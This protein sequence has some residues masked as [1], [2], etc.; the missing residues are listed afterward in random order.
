MA[1]GFGATLGVGTTDRIDTAG[2]S[3]GSTY[4]WACSVNRN[5]NGGAGFGS[6]FQHGSVG[7]GNAIFTNG[8]LGTYE[9][10]VRF[11]V[12]SG[13]WRWTRPATGSFARIMAIVDATSTGNTPAVYMNGVLQ[14]LTLATAPVGV[15]APL[16]STIIRIGNN[17]A[18]TVNWDG[19]L[20]EF[21]AWPRRLTADDAKAY[22]IGRY[23]PLLIPGGFPL[24]YVPMLRENRDYFGTDPTITGT[25]VQPHDRVIYPAG[26]MAMG[27]D[28]AA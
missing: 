18:L 8:G 4:T 11:S 27:N 15:A 5:G 14:T 28:G 25:Q 9:L 19:L 26:A 22:G 1:R 23:S 20:A 2:V 16:V 6:V 3:L 17:A 13:I 24:A 10:A 21:A 7:P 12:T